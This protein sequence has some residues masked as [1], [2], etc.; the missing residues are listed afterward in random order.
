MIFQLLKRFATS[1]CD[2]RCAYI[3]VVNIEGAERWRFVIIGEAREREG[4][5]HV[6]SI[7]RLSEQ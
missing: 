3:T 2:T 4:A 5:M 6:S 7:G 1:D